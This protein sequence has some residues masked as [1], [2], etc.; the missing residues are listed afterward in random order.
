MTSHTSQLPFSSALCAGSPCS[1][2][3]GSGTCP[4]P[5]WGRCRWR[6]A[7]FPRRSPCSGWSGWQ[8]HWVWTAGCPGW[9]GEQSLSRGTEKRTWRNHRVMQRQSVQLTALAYEHCKKELDCSS[10]NDR[11]KTFFCILIFKLASSPLTHR[12]GISLLT[13]VSGTLIQPAWRSRSSAPVCSCYSSAR[14]PRRLL[15]ESPAS[16]ASPHHYNTT[17]QDKSDAPKLINRTAYT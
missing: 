8:I 9:R 17:G 1:G 5:A 16:D 15:S 10:I 2:P 7:G 11:W 4:R 3:S 6:S 12:I 13:P 14:W